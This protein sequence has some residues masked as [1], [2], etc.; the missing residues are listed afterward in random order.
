MRKSVVRRRLP[1][2][3]Y[4]RRLLRTRHMSRHGVILLSRMIMLL[5]L[6]LI[7]RVVRLRIMFVCFSI[8]LLLVVL[9]TALRCKDVPPP[10]SLRKHGTSELPLARRRTSRDPQKLMDPSRY[11]P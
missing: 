4:S 6:T 7:V 9:V 3:I 5:R 10:C 2:V 11:L 1:R 8:L